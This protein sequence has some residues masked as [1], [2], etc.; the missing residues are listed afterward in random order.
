M[1][2]LFRTGL[3]SPAA[4]WEV[5]NRRNLEVDL[6]VE[7]TGQLYFLSIRLNPE[8][9]SSASSSSSSSVRVRYRVY[10]VSQSVISL[11][12]L[13]ENSGGGGGEAAG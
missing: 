3:F 13:A 10:P 9:P 2:Q 7:P 11:T 5:Q 12:S 8:E 4:C 1:G 6:I